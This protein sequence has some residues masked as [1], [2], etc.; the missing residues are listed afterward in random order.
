LGS[1][2]ERHGARHAPKNKKAALQVLGS[3]KY[4]QR[5]SG[6]WLILLCL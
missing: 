5:G 1:G 4:L 2:N 3:M 6:A